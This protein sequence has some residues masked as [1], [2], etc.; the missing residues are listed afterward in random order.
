MTWRNRLLTCD[1]FFC[2]LFWPRSTRTWRIEHARVR[3]GGR[4]SNVLR[5]AGVLLRSKR[6]ARK[7]QNIPMPVDPPPPSQIQWT[8]RGAWQGLTPCKARAGGGGWCTPGFWCVYPLVRKTHPF[9]RGIWHQKKGCVL[10]WVGVQWE[11]NARNQ[12][13]FC[14][15]TGLVLECDSHTGEYGA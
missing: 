9:G 11:L 14:G 8:C 4:V 15:Y 13:E 12:G 6:R 7:G 10:L 5:N 2:A 1:E 3:H